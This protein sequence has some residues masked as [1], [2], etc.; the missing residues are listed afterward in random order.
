PVEKESV[1]SKNIPKRDP[2]LIVSVGRLI[3]LKGFN[4]LIGAIKKIPQAKLVIIGEGPERPSLE[5]LIKVLGLEGRVKLTGK[6]PHNKVLEYLRRASLFVLPS[7]HEGFPHVILEAFACGCPVIATRV[8]G[9]MEIVESSVNGELVQ[10]GDEGEMETAIQ[11]F[12][13]YPTRFK[14]YA[15]KAFLILERFRQY[16]W[17]EYLKKL[18][19]LLER[20]TR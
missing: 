13:S 19:G 1:L 9:V 3:K 18:T 7:H 15:E 12:F 6:L 11:N 5:K 16:T 20:I 17:E 4:I 10:P 14:S 2:R 8:G